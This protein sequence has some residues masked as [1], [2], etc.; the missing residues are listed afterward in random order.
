MLTLYPAGKKKSF[1]LKLLE[2]PGFLHN[3]YARFGGN[4]NNALSLT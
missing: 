4:L 1:Y 2:M 3:V